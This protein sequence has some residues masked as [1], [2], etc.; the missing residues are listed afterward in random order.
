MSKQLSVYAYDT[1]DGARKLVAFSSR[2]GAAVLFGVS[3]YLL[4]THGG[5]TEKDDE[6]AV[7][8]SDPG[9]VWM[10]KPGG[11]SWEILS[12]SGKSELIQRPGG[13]RA[14]A[15][16]PRIAKHLSTQRSISLDDDA[17][18]KFME[19]GGTRYLR[20]VLSADLDLTDQEWEE[21]SARGGAQWIRAQLDAQR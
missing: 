12:D 9:A 21:L 14:G 11:T 6:V 3:I 19:L 13:V 5:V 16:K 17:H 18:G 7:A 10:R 4:T 15:G 8:L 2:A 20:K 1:P